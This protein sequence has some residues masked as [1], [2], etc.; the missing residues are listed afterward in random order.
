[1]GWIMIR[2][3]IAAL[4]VF[5][6]AVG[7]SLAVGTAASAAP[8]PPTI[9]CVNGTYSYPAAA[10]YTA[11][12]VC[13]TTTTVTWH[14]T[15]PPPVVNNN[16]GGPNLIPQALVLGTS[17][18]LTTAAPARTTPTSSNV[19][20][21]KPESSSVESTAAGSLSYTGISFNV[22]LTLTIAAL[23]VLG[24]FALVFFGGRGL[25]RTRRQ[26]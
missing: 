7:I 23:V 24:G 13:E 9:T 18:V 10:T 2:K 21:V 8:E 6:A 4:A 22:P 20:Q 25:S 11:I 5:G 16:G 14:S 19:F 3:V 12:F 26:H 15:P 17:R 1:M